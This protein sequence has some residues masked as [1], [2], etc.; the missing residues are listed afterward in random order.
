MI[1]KTR[2]IIVEQNNENVTI[3]TPDGQFIRGM[4]DGQEV[5]SE[6]LVTPLL[7]QK[8]SYQPAGRKSIPAIAVLAA[9][10]LLVLASL[11]LPLR[12]PALAF[13]QLEVNPS[14]EFGID[15]EG[16]VR[17][18][19][20]LNDDGA[21]LI[22]ELESWSGKE[23]T[24]LISLI[25]D[26]YA[27]PDREL[28][29]TAVRTGDEKLAAALDRTVRFIEGAAGEEG[30]LLRLSE[31]EPEM[32]ERSREEG[33]P[34]SRLI[35]QE[36]KPGEPASLS[37]QQE[38]KPDTET[39]KP[40]TMSADK[41]KHKPAT[42]N[43]VRPA[44]GGK[45]EARPVKNREQEQTPKTKIP[46][47]QQKPEVQKKP[48]GKSLENDTQN[49]KSQTPA[50]PENTR[51]HPQQGNPDKNN[52]GNPKGEERGDNGN[53]PA[54]AGPNKAS[55]SPGH[56]GQDKQSSPPP[57]SG[58]KPGNVE[59][60]SDKEKPVPGRSESPGKEQPDKGGHQNNNSGNGKG[61][62][63]KVPANKP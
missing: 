47:I 22:R 27:E 31:A 1:N 24:K 52:N 40:G 32:H 48:P 16:K 43:S 6:V 58:P 59:N 54:H 10:L 49:G 46:P 50:K 3:L 41:S 11:F 13:I 25:F 8:R 55:D 17:E 4:A 14:V 18:M 29:V 42:D 33:I 44:E 62:N 15:Q 61:G 21:A 36:R 53:P 38:K 9:A 45:K 57:H 63:G 35:Q 34:I 26:E 28:A 23:V 30:M 7:S 39:D 12:E 56:A 60:Q 2:G 19:A 20:A 37:P 5:G 51:P